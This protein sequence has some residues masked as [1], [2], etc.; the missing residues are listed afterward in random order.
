MVL[1]LHFFFSGQSVFMYMVFKKFC[2]IPHRP[3]FAEY[4]LLKYVLQILQTQGV[5]IDCDFRV[6]RSFN[7][8]FYSILQR[9]ESVGDHSLLGIL[10][11][12]ESRKGQYIRSISGQTRVTADESCNSHSRVLSSSLNWFIF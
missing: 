6:Q 9:V 1:N 11:F 4:R 8:T 12:L 3:I 5:N 7:H 2:Y 10:K